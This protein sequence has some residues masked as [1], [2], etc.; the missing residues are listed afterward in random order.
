[1]Q[2]SILKKE[3]ITF[4]LF[5]GYFKGERK[6]SNRA[7]KALMTTRRWQ[8]VFELA[9]ERSPSLVPAPFSD[10]ILPFLSLC[11]HNPT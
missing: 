2:W 8:Q 4:F 11:Y 5:H 9:C 6:S 10:S 1:L 3:E 7:E